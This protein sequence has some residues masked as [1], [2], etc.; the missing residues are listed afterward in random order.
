MVSRILDPP[1]T[2]F[3]NMHLGGRQW[4]KKNFLFLGPQEY[5]LAVKKQPN[6][7]K[8][9]CNL[10]IVPYFEGGPIAEVNK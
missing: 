4:E 2:P 3:Y 7:T 9:K 1:D 6:K 10:W 5:F 8:L